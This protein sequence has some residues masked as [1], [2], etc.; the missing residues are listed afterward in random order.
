[1]S[2]IVQ[3]NGTVIYQ[4]QQNDASVEALNRL[5]ARA[6]QAWADVSQNAHSF[7]GIIEQYNHAYSLESFRGDAKVKACSKWLEMIDLLKK[8][9]QEVEARQKAL[10]SDLMAWIQTE[11]NS[12]NL[13]AFQASIKGG[14]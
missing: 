6:M 2:L 1:M 3:V 13:R 11:E 7:E 12:V 9:R 10:R 4:E 5:N 8:N 14:A